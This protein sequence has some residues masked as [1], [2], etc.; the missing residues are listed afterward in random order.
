MK[1]EGRDAVDDMGEHGFCLSVT[2]GEAYFDVQ[3]EAKS[4][5]KINRT[6]CMNKELFHHADR[7]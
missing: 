2:S 7:R 3:V 4:M 5:A 6:E 1:W